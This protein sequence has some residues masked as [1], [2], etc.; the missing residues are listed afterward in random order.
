MKRSFILKNPIAF[1][2]MILSLCCVLIVLITTLRLPELT[3]GFKTG[4]RD[5]V[6]LIRKVLKDG[7]LGKFGEMMIEMLPEDLAFTVFI[8]S[9]KAFERELSLRVNESFTSTEKMDDT[10]AVISRILGFSAVP[11]TIY[12]T[13]VDYGS[14]ISYDAVSG[15]TLNISKDRDGRLVVNGVRSEMVDLKKKG[16]LVHIMDGVIMDAAFEQSVKPDDNED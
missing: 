1:V 10:Y 5:K 15:F 3:V 14:E 13:L 9:E 6:S 16:V 2:F 8:P 11:R 4:A 12:S 7:K